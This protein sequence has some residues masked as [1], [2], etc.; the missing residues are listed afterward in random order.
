MRLYHEEYR[1]RVAVVDFI[2]TPFSR[3]EIAALS[4]KPASEVRESK[5]QVYSY[6]VHEFKTLKGAR[7]CE[8]RLLAEGKSVLFQM[9]RVT[10]L[11]PEEYEEE[12]GTLPKTME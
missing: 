8:K 7:D 1:W 3:E 2:S 11:T 6:E 4:G 12:L 9:A 10:W 5:H